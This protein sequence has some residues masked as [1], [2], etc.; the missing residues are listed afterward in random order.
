MSRCRPASASIRGGGGPIQ[1]SVDAGLVYASN[2]APT[3]DPLPVTG[4]LDLRTLAAPADG[5]DGTWT[6]ASIGPVELIWPELGVRAAVTA[7][8]NARY[9]AV[10]TRRTWTRSPSSRRPTRRTAC[11]ACWMAGP[12]AWPGC[13]P[14]SRWRSTSRSRSAV[15]EPGPCQEVVR[16]APELAGVA[17]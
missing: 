7:S 10:A 12:T 1:V 13:R 15:A 11:S 8:T 3:P 17:L 14:G 16:G 6:D 4:P 5:L 9:V 2:L